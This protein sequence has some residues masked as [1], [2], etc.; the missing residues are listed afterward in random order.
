M[1]QTAG[2]RNRNVVDSCEIEHHGQRYRYLVIGRSEPGLPNELTAA[3]RDVARRAALGQTNRA[4]AGARGTSRRTVDQQLACVYQK[5][6]IT[7][8]GE[9]C[10]RVFGDTEAP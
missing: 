8:R 1:E 9:L 4:I 6:G 5:L 10:E 3:E 7:G 2:P